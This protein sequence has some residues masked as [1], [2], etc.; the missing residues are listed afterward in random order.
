MGY[1]KHQVAGI[2]GQRAVLSVSVA[3]NRDPT[4]VIGLTIQE[5]F[6]TGRKPT[7]TVALT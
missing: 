7:L 2:F 4:K 6:I 3:V 1:P 5:I